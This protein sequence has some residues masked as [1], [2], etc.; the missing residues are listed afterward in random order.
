MIAGDGPPSSCR[1]E[2]GD[3]YWQV[4]GKKTYVFYTDGWRR[5]AGGLRPSG[6]PIQTHPTYKGSLRLLGLEWVSRNWFYRN[7]KHSF[8]RPLLS[9]NLSLSVANWNVEREG[10]VQHASGAESGRSGQLTAANG[11]ET[12]AFGESSPGLL[13]QALNRETGEG[14]L[15]ILNHSDA[16]EATNSR[17]VSHGVVSSE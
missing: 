1:A 4:E 14:T 12:K 8:Q 10:K 2:P 16:D 5:S 15:D 11:V 7:R 13:T 17:G 9:E 3:L 6:L